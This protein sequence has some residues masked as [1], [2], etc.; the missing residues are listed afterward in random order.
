MV[1]SKYRDKGNGLSKY[2][3]A[4]TALLL[5]VT[6]AEAGRRGVR[7][8]FGAWGS[9]IAIAPWV[10]SSDDCP[11]AGVFG[12]GDPNSPPINHRGY[13]IWNNL[14]FQTATFFDPPL[15]QFYC[16]FSNPYSQ[17]NSDPAFYLNEQSFP[18]EEQDL[19]HFIGPNTINAVTALR[20]SFLG[21]G[22]GG[23]FG[24]QWAF[25]FFPDE[26]TVVALYGV[27]DDGS[28]Y[29]TESIIDLQLPSA[30]DEWLLWNSQRDGFGGQY[31]CFQGREYIGDCVPPAPPPPEILFLD[32]FE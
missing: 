5:V 22:S 12:E 10:G 23:S 4:A 17:L 24:R 9:S 29:S 16:Q 8:D 2:L 1:S 13:I 32:S 21:F 7:I 6:T 18:A 30:D 15:S 26:L 19:A 20:Y 3:A 11:G 28:T 27:P 31:F 25:Y 14:Y